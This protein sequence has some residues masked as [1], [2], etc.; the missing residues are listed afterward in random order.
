[1]T[2]SLPLRAA[3]VSILIFA[4][5][6]IAWHLATRGTGAVASM[7]PEYAKLMGLTATQGKSAMPGPLDVGAKLWDHLKRPFYDNG[8]NDKGL[9]IQLGYSLARVMLGYLIAVAVAI[10]LGF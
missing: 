10:P 5:F 7:S 6:M 9:G 4:T 3:F 8:P 1:L 2:R